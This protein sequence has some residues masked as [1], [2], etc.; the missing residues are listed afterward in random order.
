[1]SST[2]LQRPLTVSGCQHCG[3]PLTESNG[4]AF[5]CAGCAAAF[6]MIKGLGLGRY[7][8]ARV[9][10]ATQRPLRPESS[11]EASQL[12]RFI[13]PNKDGSYRLDLMVEG[14]QC[15]ACVWLIEAALS[16]M[17]DLLEGRVNMS[18]RRLRLVWRGERSHGAALVR[19]VE[20]LGYRLAPFDLSTLKAADDRQGQQL[21]RALAVSGFAAGNI[22]MLSIG[23]WAGGN[24]IGPATRDLLH[25]ISALIALPTVAYA[26]RPFFISAWQ[27]LRQGRASM[28]LPIS[29]GVTL[30]T[31][32]SLVETMRGGEHAYFDSAAALLFFLLIGRTMDHLARRRARIA[33]EQLI[34]LRAVTVMVIEPDDSLRP[35]AAEAVEAG[36][37][38]Q[39]ASGE[40]I[41]V[42]GVV[43]D[44]L[45]FVDQSLITGESLPRAIGPGDQIYAGSLNLGAPLTMRATAAGEGTV[46]SECV[47]LIEAAEGKRGCFVGLSD[48]V[49]RL[50]APIVHLAA[51]V[52]CL[53]WRYALN[54]PWSEALLNAAAVLIITCPC[55][56]ALAVPAVQVITAGRLFRRGILLKSPTALER[57]ASVTL[58]A[59]DKT[60]TLSEPE[61]ALRFAAGIDPLARAQAASLAAASRHPL[62][63]A[64]LR[65]QPIAG[66][67]LK[68]VKEIPGSGVEGAGP[69]GVL[70]L[71]SAAFCG[72]DQPRDSSGPALWLARPNQPAIRFDFVERAR[73]DAAAT[74]TRLRDMGLALRALSGDRPAA[75]GT[76]V[77]RIGIGQWQAN[78]TPLDKVAAIEALA[79]SGQRVLMVGDGLNDGPALAAAL[80]SMSPSTA[81][82]I[83]Q[84]AADVVFQGDNLAPVA[85][86]LQAARHAKQLIRQ[87]IIFSI[88]YNALFL[89]AAV[90]GLVTPWLAAAA[91]SSSSIIVLAN[92]FRRPRE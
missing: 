88:L 45:S 51:L 61:F 66:A 89:P 90:M 20:K 1:M 68:D 63:R 7:Y 5:C 11:H 86:V 21:T 34:A 38:M 48:R 57:L 84:N 75:V 9:I 60:G 76:L 33:A 58:V 32:M 15:G 83:S 2:L 67:A 14:L 36:W 31:V 23:V 29:V 44:G 42:D 19:Q 80:V 59:F 43:L 28:D 24:E 73:C 55:A 71:G 56:L 65:A 70:K 81:Q 92:S 37:R 39:V 41:G 16:R 30:V 82:D 27:A 69:E 49:A 78:C 13:Q 79:A 46:L 12:D 17:P 25:W 52:T 4:E 64:L 85:D 6:D 40:R 77:N 53:V 35:V 74:V 10:D 22:M 72:V 47:R 8:E 3:Q 87:N 50:Y 91:M 26:G 62:A 54:A 18:T